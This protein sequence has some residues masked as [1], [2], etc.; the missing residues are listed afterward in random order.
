MLHRRDLLQ[1]HF[2][3]NPDLNKHPDF[4]NKTLFL[5][6][7]ETAE[8]NIFTEKLDAVKARIT[9]ARSDLRVKVRFGED[10]QRPR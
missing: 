7:V 5:Q 4:T 2:A 8:T 10:S 6:E 1:S 9:K 3:K